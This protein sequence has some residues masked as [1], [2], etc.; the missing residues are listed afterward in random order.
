[1]ILPPTGIDPFLLQ[2]HVYRAI[3]SLHHLLDE[4]A[5]AGD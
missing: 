3:A 5:T 2:L 1:M 4:G